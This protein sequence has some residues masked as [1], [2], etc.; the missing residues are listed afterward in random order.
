MSKKAK[1]PLKTK[2]KKCLMD[3]VV[4]PNVPGPIS[5]IAESGPNYWVPRAAELLRAAPGSKSYLENIQTAVALLGLTLAHHTPEA[6]SKP[7]KELDGV[8]KG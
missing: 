1:Y 8:Y 5:I 6:A 2:I 4:D 7:K 3:S